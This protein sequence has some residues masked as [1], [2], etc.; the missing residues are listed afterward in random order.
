MSSTPQQQSASQSQKVPV[1]L[2]QKSSKKSRSDDVGCCWSIDSL[3]E[4]IV[5]G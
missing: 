5:R 1:P 3:W 2:K 4:M